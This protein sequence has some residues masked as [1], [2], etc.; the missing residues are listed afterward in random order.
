[1]TR[2]SRLVVILLVIAA[3]GVSGLMVVANK[4]RKALGGNGTSGSAASEE[5]RAHAARLVDGVLALHL[6]FERIQPARDAC[7][8][9][10]QG[11]EVDGESRPHDEITPEEE[12]VALH[13]DL[14]AASSSAA[15]RSSRAASRMREATRSP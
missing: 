1:M 8:P 10:R 13:R 3:V 15:R 5:A 2:Q 11:G 12:G 6:S 9:P 4:Y 14:M 7:H